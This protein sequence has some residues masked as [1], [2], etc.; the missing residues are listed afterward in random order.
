VRRQALDLAEDGDRVARSR[1]HGRLLHHLEG[2]VMPVYTNND[3][4]VARRR[5]IKLEAI[6]SVVA[7]CWRHKATDSVNTP[8]KGHL[9]RQIAKPPVTSR[10]SLQK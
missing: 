2:N 4:S 3:N 6:L 10:T 7:C 1:H 9:K 5:A 8:L